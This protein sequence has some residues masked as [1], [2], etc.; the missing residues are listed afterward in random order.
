MC[1]GGDVGA[2]IA[3]LFDI[4]GC[5]I[6]DSSSLKGGAISIEYMS[7]SRDPFAIPYQILITITNSIFYRNRAL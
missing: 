5:I 6:A 1:L 7:E 3:N 2:N 4:D